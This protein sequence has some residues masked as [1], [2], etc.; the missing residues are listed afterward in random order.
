MRTK[1][2]ATAVL[3]TLLSLLFLAVTA[4]AAEQKVQIKVPGVV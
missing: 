1:T 2:F 4:Y 3:T